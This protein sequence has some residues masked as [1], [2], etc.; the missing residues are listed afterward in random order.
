MISD[1]DKSL[2]SVGETNSIPKLATRVKLDYETS[3]KYSVVVVAQDLAN[4]CH[5]SR[6]LVQINVIDQN[7]NRPTFEK[8]KYTAMI[9]ENAQSD[10]FVIKVLILAFF[11]F[12]TKT[13]SL[14][15][16]YM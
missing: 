5:K 14:C 2:F 16:Y 6:A 4:Q 7:D 9:S 3:P 8:N 10:A 15:H 13:T 11:F 1:G 12:D